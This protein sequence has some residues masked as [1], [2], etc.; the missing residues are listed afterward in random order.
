MS[1]EQVITVQ[2]LYKEDTGSVLACVCDFDDTVDH[3]SM[4]EGPQ[5]LKLF[6]SLLAATPLQEWKNHKSNTPNCTQY[7]IW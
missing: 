1:Q 7:Q 2:K 6:E 3:L 5:H 4:P